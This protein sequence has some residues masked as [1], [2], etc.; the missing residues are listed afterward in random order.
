MA[1]KRSSGRVQ[2]EAYLGRVVGRRYRIA[3]ALAVGGMGS[4]FVAEQLNLK[5]EVAMKVFAGTDPLH[6][7]RFRREAE[8]LASLSHPAIVEVYDFLTEFEGPLAAGYLVM[9]YVK[10]M[11]LE[12]YLKS[13]PDRRLVQS[14]IVQLL[15]PVA[16]AL[17]ELHA[18][19]IIHRDIKPANIIRFE[20]ADGRPGVKLVDFGVARRHDDP[21]ITALGHV[22]GTPPYLSP[23]ALAGKPHTPVSDIFSFGATIFELATGQP[24]FGRE[25]LQ[26]IV[27][28]TLEEEVQLPPYLDSTPLGGLIRAMLEKNPR[29]RP[30][31]LS[32]VQSM[33]Q[34]PRNSA[35]STGPHVRDASPSE[36]PWEVR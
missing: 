13:K 2:V 17:V 26:S 16:S 5:R 27:M 18:S 31:S 10:G 22:L 6:L 25:S 7:E 9:A 15:V 19:G 20:R 24:P 28:R 8:A 11:D 1:D 4:V 34:L 14:E 35:P 33:E 3:R 29:H 32:V 21:G 23:E 30:D 36:T 12:D